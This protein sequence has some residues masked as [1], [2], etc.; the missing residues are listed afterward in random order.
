M[1]AFAVVVQVRWRLRHPAWTQQAEVE[2]LRQE[3][4]RVQLAYSRAQRG[5]LDVLHPELGYPAAVQGLES[6]ADSDFADQVGLSAVAVLGKH[7]GDLEGNL[8]A[9]VQV[10]TSQ[11]VEGHIAYHSLGERPGHQESRVDRQGAR[12]ERSD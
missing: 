4:V 7:H 12:I 1:L 2:R 5:E 11:V 3:F 6:S 9:L 8:V 10:E